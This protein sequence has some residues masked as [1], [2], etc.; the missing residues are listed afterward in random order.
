MPVAKDFGKS[1]V[2]S[3]RMYFEKMRRGAERMPGDD[4]DGTGVASFAEVPGDHLPND[5]AS[6]GQ[7]QVEWHY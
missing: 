1:A 3:L 6:A 4:G 5:M 2:S 7:A